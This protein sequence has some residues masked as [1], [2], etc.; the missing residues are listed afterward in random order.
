MCLAIPGKVTSVEGLAANVDFRGVTV[1]VRTDLLP[2]TG[3]GDWILIHAGF[4]IQH[5][6]PDEAREVL[7]TI[8]DAFLAADEGVPGAGEPNRRAPT[9]G[10]SGGEA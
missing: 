9:E 1:T 5:L 7:A 3:V 8:D 2:D 10:D 6:Q 4:A